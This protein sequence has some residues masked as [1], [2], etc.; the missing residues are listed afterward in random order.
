LP[1][2]EAAD[3]VLQN[4]ITKGTQRPLRFFDSGEGAA[5]EL[6]KLGLEELRQYAIQHGEPRS[7]KRQAGVPGECY[8]QVYIGVT[9][10]G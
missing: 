6:G 10:D 7:K 1:G 4:R 9:V 2:A 5:F 3:A 8:Q